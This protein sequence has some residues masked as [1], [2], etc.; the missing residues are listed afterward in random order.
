MKKTRRL[1]SLLL[2]L[3]LLAA[4]LVQP[5]FAAFDD[6]SSDAWYKDAVD[7]VEINGLF[8]GATETRFNPDGTMTRGM[9]ATVLYRVHRET[10]TDYSDPGYTDVPDGSYYQVPIYWGTHAGI[11]NGVGYGSFAPDNPVT[12]E[13]MCKL[14]GLYFQYLGY[15]PPQVNEEVTFT[16]AQDISD[17]AVKWVSFCQTS[18]LITGYS[19]GSFRPQGEATRAEVAAIISRLGTILENVGCVVGH[20]NPSKDWRMILV[21]PWNYIP[22]GYVDTISTTAIT[23]TSTNGTQYIDSRAYEDLCAMVSAMKSAGLSPY[24]NSGFRTHAYQQNLY[25]NKVSQYQS[26]GY[27]LEEAK[28]L[29]AQWVAV[30]GTSEHELG[31]AVDIDMNAGN[32][33]SWLSQ[34]SWRYGFI[35]RYQDGKTDITGIQ[36]EEWHYRYVGRDNARRIYESG[37]CLEEYWELYG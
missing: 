36:P 13:Q 12:R 4:L 34:N 18:G 20:G 9:F 5:A 26:Y 19:D 6:V 14:I 10:R 7:Y 24:I 3:S 15:T 21:N 23:C 32:S 30:P 17:Y 25:N 28:R 27:S 29:A 31:L 35:Y 37:L 1:L 11:I 16:D 22:D 2:T 8:R 33:F